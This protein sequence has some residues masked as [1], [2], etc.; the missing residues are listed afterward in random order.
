MKIQRKLSNGTWITEDRS[1]MFINRAAEIKKISVEKVL[2]MLESGDEVQYDI[3]W[4][5]QIRKAV[6]ALTENELIERANRMAKLYATPSGFNPD[7][8]PV[9]YD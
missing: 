2:E 5:F 6:P 8:S 7:G 4:Y 9:E 1:D 3:G